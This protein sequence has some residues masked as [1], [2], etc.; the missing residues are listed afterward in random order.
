MEGAAKGGGVYPEV[1]FDI[2]TKWYQLYERVR[3]AG[4]GIGK[5][6]PAA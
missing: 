5:R 2:A 1:L 6:D 4:R 3:T